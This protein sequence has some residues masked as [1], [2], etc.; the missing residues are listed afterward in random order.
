MDS[1]ESVVVKPVPMRGVL[2]QECPIPPHLGVFVL[3]PNPLRA[4]TC[5][6]VKVVMAS[7]SSR[8]A[9]CE[10]RRLQD[11]LTPIGTQEKCPAFTDGRGMMRVGCSHTTD[12]TTCVFIERVGFDVCVFVMGLNVRFAVEFGNAI[13]QTAK[14]VSL[15]SEHAASDQF[16]LADALE[17]RIALKQAWLQR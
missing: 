9:H 12:D 10:E 11:E 1:P 13:G 6:A 15:W 16:L 5:S 14:L 7:C 17:E 8:S 4:I 2:A 3:I